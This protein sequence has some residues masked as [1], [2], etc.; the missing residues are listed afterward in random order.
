MNRGVMDIMVSLLINLR[1]FLFV[2]W[3][4][5]F[6]GQS[7]ESFVWTLLRNGALG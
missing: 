1:L 3:F 2:V 6:F 7:G 5:V 4:L